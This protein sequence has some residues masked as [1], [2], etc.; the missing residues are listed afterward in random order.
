MKR[1]LAILALVGVV[2]IV[3][4]TAL[5]VDEPEQQE[6]ADSEGIYVPPEQ[7][8]ESGPMTEQDNQ[9]DP[10]ELGGG[11][12]GNGQPPS[13]TGIGAPGFWLDPILVMLMNLV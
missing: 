10:D 9:G 7:E 13:T 6:Q 2:L 11:F 4:L 1:L 5:A 3:P 12:R 8:H